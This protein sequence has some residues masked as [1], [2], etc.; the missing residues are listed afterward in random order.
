MAKKCK[1]IAASI[2]TADS[3]PQ[4]VRKIISD[5]LVHVFGTYKE[6][7]HPF[8]KTVSELV[9][10][11]LET[12]QANLQAAINQARERKATDETEAGN[13]AAA[14]DAAQAASDAAN[15]AMASAKAACA[16]SHNALKDAKTHLQ[17]LETAVKTAEA[18][19]TT[20]AAKKEKLEALVKEFFTPVKQ[21]TLDKG[22][23]KSAAWV[24]KHLGKEFS[25][26][27]EH[28]FVTCVVR[29]FSKAASAW[30]TFDH[31]IDKELDVALKNIVDGLASELVA[32]EA[33][34][35]KRAADVE[36]AA[37]A[38]TTATENAKAAEEVN[39]N[40]TNA[41]KDAKA[42]AKAAA[43]AAK[44]HQKHTE[45]AADAL[46]HAEHALAAFQQG[47][48]AA[49]TDAE[50]HT[51]PPPPPAPEPE[52]AAVDAAM[53]PAPAPAARAAPSI[54]PSPGV[55]SWVAQASG[56]SR[57]PQVAPSPQ[58]ASSPRR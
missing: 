6:E 36:A 2:R 58:V 45:K 34:K 47:A 25:A 33:A 48:L 35:G 24:G 52:A 32:M 57:S 5:R 9:G 3:L 21:G 42:A 28:E 30:G 29:T 15:Q 40:A 43:A 23:N 46:E 27:L 12:T 44:A 51:A 56:L 37:A 18:D 41:A 53:A 54:L 4:P 11:T 38:I 22:L 7:R 13:L 20:T 19:A 26:S 10:K 16:D 1:K 8:Q 39:T 14:N 55:L 50:A 31:I 49:F 17:D